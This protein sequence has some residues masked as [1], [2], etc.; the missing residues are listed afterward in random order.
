[1]TD[2]AAPPI[3]GPEAAARIRAGLPHEPCISGAVEI[4]KVCADLTRMKILLA[5]RGREMRVADLARVAGIS[6]SAASHQLRLLRAHQIV[7]FRKEG[8]TAWYRL[9]DHHVATLL[10]NALDHAHEGHGS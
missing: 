7:A 10:Q 2:T 6:E 3:S 8:R 4:L 9:A 1:M 5:L